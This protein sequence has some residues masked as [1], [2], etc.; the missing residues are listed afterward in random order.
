MK[1]EVRTSLYDVYDPETGLN[2]IDLGLIYD[3]EWSP[4]NGEVKVT[5]T[6]TTPA[7]PAGGVMISGVERRVSTISGVEQ[8]TVDVTFEPPWTPEKITP[9]GRRQLGWG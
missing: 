9:E 1:K 4:E 3:V 2:L 8:V 6:F 7:C 5:M